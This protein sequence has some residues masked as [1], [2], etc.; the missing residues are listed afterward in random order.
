MR[1][2]GRHAVKGLRGREELAETG[3]VTRELEVEGDGVFD[4][5]DATGWDEG[6]SQQWLD[7]VIGLSD[8]WRLT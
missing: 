4:T 8:I 6:L 5:V 3:D 7:S 2:D 1:V